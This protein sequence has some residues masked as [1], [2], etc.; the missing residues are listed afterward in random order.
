M[1]K[2]DLLSIAD[3]SP[4]EIEGV[5]RRAADLKGGATSTALAGKSVALLF[6][7]PSLRTK[8]GTEECFHERILKENTLCFLRFE[9]MSF[10]FFLGFCFFK[11]N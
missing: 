1:N 9:V 8:A 11:R 10:W 3:L 2:K 6:E 7:K 5:L 4:S